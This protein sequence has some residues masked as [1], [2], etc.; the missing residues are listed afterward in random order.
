MEAGLWWRGKAGEGEE[1]RR[2]ERRREDVEE[3]IRREKAA[4]D[5]QEQRLSG[6]K[7]PSEFVSII[8]R[9]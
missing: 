8:D 7:P 9:I 6:L 3:E 2:R 4:D 5:Y 1:R